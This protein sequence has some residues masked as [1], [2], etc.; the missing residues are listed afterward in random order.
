MDM[1]GG[2]ILTWIIV[3]IPFAVEKYSALD[4]ELFVAVR[5]FLLA[6]LEE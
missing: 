4:V 1:N 2:P 3:R 5:M 6:T